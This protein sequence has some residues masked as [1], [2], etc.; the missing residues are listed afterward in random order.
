MMNLDELKK[1]EAKATP[2]EWYA[3]EHLRDDACMITAPLR[4]D[5]KHDKH[6]VA[7]CVLDDIRC[8]DAEFIAEF[9]NS[10]KEMIET[11]ERY[12]IALED[13]SDKRYP[14]GA[15]KPEG[16][17]K[18]HAGRWIVHINKVLDELLKPIQTEAKKAL[19]EPEREQPKS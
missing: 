7:T 17:D 16:C 1:L 2:G 10:A 14:G 8:D 9:R 15:E 3:S 19:K 11:I 4:P 18:W 6:A 5:E 12:K 13:I